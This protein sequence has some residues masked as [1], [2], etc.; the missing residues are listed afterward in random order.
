MMLKSKLLVAVALLGVSLGAVGHPNTSV[1]AQIK[2]TLDAG[3]QSTTYLSG[4]EAAHGSDSRNRIVSAVLTA[5][6]RFHVTA[7]AEHSPTEFP[8]FLS[9][10][11]GDTFPGWYERDA[12][13]IIHAGRTYYANIGSI[14]GEQVDAHSNNEWYVV[15]A[16]VYETTPTGRYVTACEHVH[17]T[18]GSPLDAD[19]SPHSS[20]NPPPVTPTT[21]WS[22]AAFIPSLTMRPAGKGV[23]LVNRGNS[24]LKARALCFD[25]EDD[26]GNAVAWAGA[27]EETVSPRERV[28]LDRNYFGASRCITTGAGKLWAVEVQV[29]GDRCNDLYVSAVDDWN[30]VVVYAPVVSLCD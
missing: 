7:I 19:P 14:T 16:G 29:K 28:R 30:G 2:P 13:K 3:P 26:S 11:P 4:C 10:H 27:G 20:P 9:Y 23:H 18:L 1:K 21:T 12:Q 24:D 8:K 17:V 22:D 6:R 5:E 25:D 15:V